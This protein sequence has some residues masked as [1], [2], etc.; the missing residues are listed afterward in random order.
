MI[1]LILLNFLNSIENLGAPVYME[2][3]KDPPTAYYLIDKTGSS[4]TNH[5]YHSTIAIQSYAPSLYEAATANET[6]KSLMLDGFLSVPQI[7]KVELNSDYDY[8]DTQ[9]KRYRYQ[10][11][12]DITHY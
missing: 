9:S 3:P 11:V 7:A 10:A 1:E 12:F 5:I 6:I 4:L 8:S 2:T